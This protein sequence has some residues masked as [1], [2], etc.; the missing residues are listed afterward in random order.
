MLLM[1][2]DAWHFLTGAIFKL[3]L[4]FTAYVLNCFLAFYIECTGIEFV[5]CEFKYVPAYNNRTAQI[6]FPWQKSIC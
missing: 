4:K 1:A 6:A 2:F 3:Y 5:W